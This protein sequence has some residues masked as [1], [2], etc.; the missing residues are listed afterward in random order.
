LTPVLVDPPGKWCE[1]QIGADGD[2]RR[3]RIDFVGSSSKLTFSGY[4]RSKYIVSSLEGY[5]FV[6]GIPI[7]IIPGHGDVRQFRVTRRGDGDEETE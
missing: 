2:P 4:E 7:G 3:F 6:D 5:P 1:R